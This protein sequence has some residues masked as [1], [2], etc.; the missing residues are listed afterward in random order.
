MYLR[1]QDSF[2]LPGLMNS[3]KMLMQFGVEQTK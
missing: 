2:E 1:C 3:T